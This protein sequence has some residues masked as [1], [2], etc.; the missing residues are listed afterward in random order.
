MRTNRRDFMTSL[1]RTV[2]G[3]AGLAWMASCGGGSSGNTPDAHTGGGNCLQNGTAVTISGN[4]GHV[5][6]VTKDEVSAGTAKTYDI[7][8]TASHTHSVTVTAAHFTT[9]AA[10]GTVMTTTTTTNS[11]SHSITIMCA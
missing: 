3:A 9:L 11:H 8:G 1:A 7:M 6:V 4:H 5:L 2:A 10:G